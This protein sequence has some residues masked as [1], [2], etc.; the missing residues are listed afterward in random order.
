MFKTALAA[1]E[2]TVTRISGR[3]FEARPFSLEQFLVGA[4]GLY[5]MGAA[6]HRAAYR[7]GLFNQ[8][9]LACPV[10]SIGNITAGGT[11]KTPMAVFLANLFLE[12]NHT[13][14][15]VSRGYKGTL[16]AD[17]AVVGDGHQ[18]LLDSNRAGDE[19]HM[20]A[21]LKQFPVV[22]GKDRFTAGKLALEIFRPDVII[23]DD[24]FQHLKLKR[25]LDLV[26]LDHDRPFGNHRLLPAGRLRELPR[27]A[28]QRAHAV[29]LTRGPD[30][31]RPRDTHPAT[32][33]F[34][35]LPLFFTRHK[36]YVAAWHA[37]NGRIEAA[38]ALSRFKS[39]RLVLFSGIADNPAFA[40]TIRDQG[41]IILDHLEF[42]DHYRYKR[43]DISRV[44]ERA[45][46]TGADCIATTEKDWARL[47]PDAARFKGAGTDLAVI[48][49]RIEFD[50]K[51]KFEAFIRDKVTATHPAKRRA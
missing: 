25:D 23:L 40:G 24:G 35:G 6:L 10:I 39:R 15:V 45:A 32:R 48:G 22:V 1:F 49:I 38:G 50:D 20:M 46:Q 2:E 37:P 16:G 47:G 5:R 4:S 12:M 9:R 33:A 36:P 26:L 30:R 44:L 43:S 27:T 13:P 18:V 21:C 34:P 11:G 8:N 14:V 42:T 3:D 7:S 17:A 19:P 41:G 28:A 29:I 31:P 51:K